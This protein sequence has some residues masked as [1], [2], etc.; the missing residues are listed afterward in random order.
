MSKKP[1][2]PTASQSE[3]RKHYYLDR[4]VIIAPGRNLRP[5]SFSHE[6]DSH[7]MADPS[8]HF[9][10]NTEPALTAIPGPKNWRV[11]AIKN[12]FPALSLDN[13]EAFGSQEVIIETPSLCPSI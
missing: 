8:C 4:F 9:C 11:K 5:D 6:G 2:Q 13:P 12:A 1:A 7:K 10:N 3:I